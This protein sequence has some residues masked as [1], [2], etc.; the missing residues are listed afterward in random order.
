MQS[1]LG[2][3]TRRPTRFGRWAWA[4]GTPSGCTCPWCRSWWSPCWRRPGRDHWWHELVPRQAESAATERT[5][6]E[7]VLMVI[8]TSGTTGAPKG[9]V[10]THCGFP[11]KAAQDMPFGTEVHPGDRP[12]WMTD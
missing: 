4:K 6:A 7:D 8:Y 5:A 11:V 12:Y 9:A 2:W 3:S 10:H 1:W